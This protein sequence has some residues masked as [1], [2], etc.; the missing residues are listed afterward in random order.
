MWV[1]RN[2]QSTLVFEI[3]VLRLTGLPR[4][5]LLFHTYNVSTSNFIHESGESLYI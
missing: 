3:Y 1:K 2:T 5:A 4:N